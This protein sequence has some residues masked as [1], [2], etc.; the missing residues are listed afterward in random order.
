L[1]CKE[2]SDILRA[3]KWI[4][5]VHEDTEYTVTIDTLDRYNCNYY[6]HGD[7]PIFDSEGVDICG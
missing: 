1:K 2:R 3:C 4:D 7:D 5:E 6:A